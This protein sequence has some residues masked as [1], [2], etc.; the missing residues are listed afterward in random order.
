MKWRFYHQ[1]RLEEALLRHTI[2][3]KI[4]SFMY[5]EGKPLKKQSLVVKNMIFLINNGTPL[6]VFKNKDVILDVF[7]SN[8]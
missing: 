7:Y 8:N 3:L 2:I 5:L 4:A 1:L 6:A